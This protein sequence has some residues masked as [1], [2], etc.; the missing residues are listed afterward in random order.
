MGEEN[1]DRAKRNENIRDSASINEL[2]VLAN[3]QSYNAEMM[4]DGDSKQD[5]FNK[6]R[7]MATRQ[8]EA[9][10]QRD[11]LKSIKRSAPDTYLVEHDKE[12]D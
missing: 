7:Q 9:L 5:R 10:D 6:L 1:P 8:L 11:F 12:K 2:N 3:V 4:S